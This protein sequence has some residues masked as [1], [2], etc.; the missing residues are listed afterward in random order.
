MSQLE[1]EL[2]KLDLDPWWDEAFLADQERYLP[3]FERVLA[4]VERARV[5]G[6]MPASLLVTGPRGLGR[7]RLAI[8]L[9]ALATCPE[10]GPQGCG[11]ASCT[12]VRKGVHPDVR[13]VP[14]PNNKKQIVIQQIR[15]IV[16]SVAGHPYEGRA[17]VWILDGVET[18]NLGREAANAFLKVLEEPPDHV[19]FI[20][21]A[22]NP[23]RVLPTI[24]SRC[25]RLQLPGP[26]GL[27]EAFGET[28]PVAPE[29]LAVVPEKRAR[30]GENRKKRDDRWRKERE[31]ALREAHGGELVA[32]T[33]ASLEE[34]MG[35]EP[36]A[37]IVAARRLAG[38][39]DPYQTAALAALE[40]AGRHEGSP[41]GEGLSR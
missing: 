15:E 40:L 23:E 37:L 22:A 1:S 4:R 25:Q 32:A 31:A 17:R 38:V 27:G 29:L 12:R 8:E 13:Y 3:A 2:D 14:R 30:K 24:L 26:L 9:A 33:V 7:E 20:L 21:L 11:C 6:R 16:G 28:P 18:G 34:A 10:G 5:S 39:G 41:A 36:L 19:R 35:G